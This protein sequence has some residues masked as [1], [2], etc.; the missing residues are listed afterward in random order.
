MQ[1]L[2]QKNAALEEENSKLKAD[3]GSKVEKEETAET[4]M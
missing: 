4:T 2:Q 3:L 1:E